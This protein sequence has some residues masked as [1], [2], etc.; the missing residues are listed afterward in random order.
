MWW[1][2]VRERGGLLFRLGLPAAGL[3]VGAT[4]DCELHLPGLTETLKIEPARREIWLTRGSRAAAI[5]SGEPFDVGPYSFTAS[6]QAAAPG[7]SSLRTQWLRYD[8]DRQTITASRAVLRVVEG[9]DAP[10]EIEIDR[11]ALVIGGQ[12]GCDVALTDEFVSGR[13]A[14]LQ[15]SADGWTIVDLGSRNGAYLDEMRVLSAV[16]PPGAKLRLGKTVLTLAH[17]EDVAAAPIAED[18]RFAGMVG[19]SEATRRV[20]GLIR[21]VAPTDATVLVEGPTGTGKELVARAIHSVSSRA[22]GPFVAV[23]CGSVAHELI[24]EELFGHVKGAFTGAATDRQGLFELAEHGTLLLDEIGELPLDLQPNLLRVL[25]EH[26]VRRVGCA[27]ATPVD[28]RVVAATHCDLRAEAA[29]GRFRPDLLHRLNTFPIALTPLRDRLDDLPPLVEHLLAR[30]AARYHRAP[31]AVGADAMRV[32][33]AHSW[34]GNVRELAN[35]LG[36]S[37]LLAGSRDRLHAADLALSA[38][39]LADPNAPAPSLADVERNVIRRALESFPTRREAAAHLGIA[40]STMYAKMK[41]Y[42]LD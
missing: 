20:F 16:W 3:R 22:E 12:L 1:L 37:L 27:R 28:V 40:P 34:P 29:A 36:R 21:V 17:Q 7:A 31:P 5:P 42:G 11:D 2:E 41:E 8:A 14:R 15:L 9:P 10:R 35:V 18:E 13:H 26:E 32:L 19:R 24:A 33:L 23:N 6:T 30:E 39:P 25:E 38:D 4:D